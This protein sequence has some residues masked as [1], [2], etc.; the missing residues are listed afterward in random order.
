MSWN[1]HSVADLEADLVDLEGQI[2]ELRGQQTV[3]VRELEKAQ[4]P[5][6]DGSR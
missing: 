2:G 3:L 1:R 6:T 5:Q 4:A